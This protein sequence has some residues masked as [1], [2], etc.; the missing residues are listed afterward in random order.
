M[1][2]PPDNSP[3]RQ[4][5]NWLSPADLRSRGLDALNHIED[6]LTRRIFTRK[7]GLDGAPRQDIDAIADLCDTTPARAQM[8][9]TRALHSIQVVKED[10]CEVPILAETDDWVCVAKP[11]GMRVTPFVRFAGGSLLN[12]VARH[13]W[14]ND[15]SGDECSPHAVHR[16]DDFTSGCVVFAKTAAAAK[17]LQEQWQS[18]IRKSYIAL[19]HGTTDER[20]ITCSTPLVNHARKAQSA[21]TRIDILK[22]SVDKSVTLAKCTLMGTGRLH[23]I[24]RHCAET[25]RLPLVGDKLYGGWSVGGMTRYALHAWELTLGETTVRCPLPADFVACLASLD[26]LEGWTPG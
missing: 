2:T 4:H 26:G 8:L 1:T 11:A 3:A 18:N 10:Q 23:Q 21:C 16:V 19:L 12:H 6:P 15:A 9:L 25:L 5:D 22:Q 13:L 7:F 14:D 17:N 24:R 20:T